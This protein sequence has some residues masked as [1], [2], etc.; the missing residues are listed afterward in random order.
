MGW[1][2]PEIAIEDLMKLI[3]NYIDM[4][5]L[6]S[7]Y[8]S[9]G[10]L[11]NWDSNN[12]NRSFQWALF[13][14]NVMKALLSSADYEESVEELDALLHELT[15]DPNFPQGLAHLSC[16]ILVRA[17]DL[18]LDHLIHTFPLRESHLK[19]ITTASV[20]MDI[21]NL[22]SRESNGLDVYLEKLMLLPSNGPNLDERIN[23][24]DHDSW[25]D[26]DFSVAAIQKLGIR[27]SAVSCSTVAE[28]GLENIWKTL[29]TKMHD[30]LASTSNS[31]PL[32]QSTIGE[33]LP[34]ESDYWNCWR[35]RSLSYMLDKRTIRMISG[36]SVIFS[37]PEGQWTQVLERLNLPAQNDD[38]S[39]MIELLL[40]GCVVNKW[41]ALL[42]HLMSV[43]YEFPAISKLYHEVISLPPGKSQNFFLNEGLMNSK[44]KSVV[45]YLEVLI[46]SKVNQLWQ[47]PPVLA[48][49]AIPSW[50]KLFRSYLHELEG[51]L[52][53]NSLAT[54]CLAGTLEHRECEV[55]ERIWCLY[56]FHVC[57]GTG[58]SNI[59]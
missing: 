2:Y 30:E 50:S 9:T 24:E 54:S 26:G 55:G 38:I 44:E 14:E 46:S 23:F 1:S 33:E 18:M 11:A 48:A 17:K 4:L 21:S 47:L 43:S 41:S 27:Q 58:R 31:E 16:A 3:K 13:L 40:L 29:R 7:G 22:K 34:L 57:S 19:A 28:A 5:I 42:E 37:A 32:K 52:I 8:Q 59:A 45:D 15:L 10:R 20:E 36:A 6:A 56:T 25:G 51:Q 39:E 49:I 12:I 53:G 35:A